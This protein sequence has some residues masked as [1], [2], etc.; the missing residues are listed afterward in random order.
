MSFQMLLTYFGVFNLL[1]KNSN[2]TERIKNEKTS[3][4]SGGQWVNQ[5]NVFMKSRICIYF[6]CLL[7]LLLFL[8]WFDCKWSDIN[9]AALNM[10]HW[11]FFKLLF[12]VAFIFEQVFLFVLCVLYFVNP[13]KFISTEN[14]IYSNE[15]TSITIS[16]KTT[17]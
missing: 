9:G 11:T 12:L 7:L 15:R 16:I 17:C 10:I 6:W 1:P 13:V 2:Q 5:F 14:H 4:D 3:Y 8:V